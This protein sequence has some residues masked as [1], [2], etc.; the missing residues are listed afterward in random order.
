MVQ[1]VRARVKALRERPCVGA[2]SSSIKA[3][4]L[5]IFT[6]LMLWSNP[7]PFPLP[8]HF[9]H[10]LPHHLPALAKLWE[11]LRSGRF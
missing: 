3:L 1:L 5:P 8:L 6:L 10:T 11:A 2:F 7:S 4:I 9:L